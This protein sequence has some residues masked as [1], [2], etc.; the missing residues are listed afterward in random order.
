M[1]PGVAKL[2]RGAGL[3]VVL[4]A[5]DAQLCHQRQGGERFG[6]RA[7]DLG[8]L[9]AVGIGAKEAAKLIGCRYLEASPGSAG[10]CAPAS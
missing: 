7:Q 6:E 2:G 1:V 10:G 4:L 9:G 3:G 5:G 8:Q